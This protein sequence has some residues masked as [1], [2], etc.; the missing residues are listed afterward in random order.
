MIPD[1]DLRIAVIGNDGRT[2][3][4]V[5]KI[6]QSPLV[7]D[8]AV[9][10]GNPG[11][12][13]EPKVRNVE[14]PNQKPTAIGDW[15]QTNR[16]H[17]AVV[18][19]EAPL[20]AGLA[21]ELESRGI[22]VFGPRIEGTVIEKSK[23]FCKD[24]LI[25][26]NIPTPR[27][28][29]CGDM[30][31]VR[32]RIMRHDWPAPMVLAADG[33]AAGKGVGIVTAPADALAHAERWLPQGPMLDVEFI[34]GHELSMFYAVRNGRL[35]PF[36]NA[37]DYK[38]RYSGDI[39]PNTGSMGSDSPAQFLD[40]R[41]EREIFETIAKPTVAALAEEKIAYTGTMFF[42]LTRRKSDGKVFVLEINCRTGDSETQAMLMR[43]RSDIVPFMAAI[44]RDEEPPALLWDPRPAVCIT[45]VVKGYAETE[46]L[47]LGNPI[48]GLERLRDIPDFKVFHAGTARQRGRLV[49]ARGRVLNLVA[50]RRTAH[51]ANI[52][53]HN[54]ANEV[55]FR[56][57]EWR[58]DIGIP[59]RSDR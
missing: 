58:Y 17:F 16:V 31:S 52:V 36:G 19:P 5:W 4:L 35:W 57:R 39:G 59:L 30:E 34:D 55:Q 21:D 11:T 54:A 51:E 14:L 49:T 33:P 56:G 28:A 22:P 38:R 26:H 37:R 47:P 2:H 42:G 6:A 20:Y 41:L 50:K 8:V 29:P 18:G 10:P 48:F 44:L 43:L 32:R 25:R 15:C 24:L 40:A 13:E 12:A 46:R 27:Y 7:A 9:F 53:A 23:S 3:A 45:L 1:K